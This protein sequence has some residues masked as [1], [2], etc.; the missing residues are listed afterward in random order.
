[1]IVV[2]A[3]FQHTNVWEIVVRCDTK[4][5]IIAIIAMMRLTGCVRLTEWNCARVACWRDWR[6]WNE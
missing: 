1:M 2:V 4:N 5:I 3:Q 6:L